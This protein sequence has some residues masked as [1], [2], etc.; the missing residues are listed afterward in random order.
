[1]DVVI[2]TLRGLLNTTPNGMPERQLWRDF[3]GIEGYEV[4]YKSYGYRTFIEFLQKSN[5]F[6][7]ANLPDGVHIR[8]KLSKASIHLAEMVQS[9]NRSK[10]KRSERNILFT[11]R[12]RSALSTANWGPRTQT[13]VLKLN[14]FSGFIN[15][16][17]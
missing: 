16:F 10:K 3:R 2:K 9:Q 15:T 1:M 11:P 13:K 6:D 5:E 17:I 7:I 12:L 14:L 8:A 4:P